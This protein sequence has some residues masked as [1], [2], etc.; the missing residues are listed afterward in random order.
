M[1]LTDLI[2]RDLPP[3]HWLVEEPLV[4]ERYMSVWDIPQDILDGASACYQGIELLKGLDHVIVGYRI[5]VAPNFKT[6]LASV[7]R[8]LRA[9]FNVNG[10]SRKPAVLHDF[11]YHHA[12]FSRQF[13][14]NEFKHALLTCNV[15]AVE[16]NAMYLGV[17]AG[18]SGTYN[19]YRQQRAV[20]SC[21]I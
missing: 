3:S 6:D 20:P 2:T 4:Y 15:G 14:D 5:T 13:C 9:V 18:G 10:R 17:R 7:P 21:G 8:P 11:L 19:K 16:R 1:F 12:L